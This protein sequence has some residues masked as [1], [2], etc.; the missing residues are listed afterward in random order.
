MF[1]QN[2]H[3]VPDGFRAVVDN[4]P[5]AILIFDANGK[6][7]FVNRA[8]ASLVLDR[9]PQTAVEDIASL[10]NLVGPLRCLRGSPLDRTELPWARLE[11][12]E[13]FRDYELR[14]EERWATGRPVLSFTGL[15]VT[16]EG[17]GE[18]LMM[19]LIED[20]TAKH[21]SDSLFRTAFERGPVPVTLVRG[22]DQCVLDANPAFLEL[23]GYEHSEVVGH[24]VPELSMVLNDEH[25]QVASE[26]L[27]RGEEVERLEVVVRARD[28]APRTLLSWHRWV[29][30]SGEECI[31]GVYVDI[32]DQKEME[33]KLREATQVVLQSAS[34]FS[35]SVVQQLERLR[36]PDR[37]TVVSGEIDL[38]TRREREVVIRV[39]AG[40]SNM[41]IADELTLTPQT[42]R[43]YV[44]RIYR[45]IGVTNRAE[46]V[47]W[48]R[49]R[50][51][52]QG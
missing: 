38:L 7:R 51:L 3:H 49:E 33:R 18:P 19:L 45:K 43:N 25:L 2:G 41:R 15:T 31:L 10:S 13:S 36:A 22:A 52:V 11:R 27:A 47:V 39:G 46:A 28:E 4:L 1:V 42:V 26:R 34:V 17:S 5:Q 50:G 12:G 24:T 8:A 16:E 44:T 30:V 37:S 9:Q 20:V 32:S 35:R 48:A 21:E 23:L 6:A 40:H 29:E 14:A